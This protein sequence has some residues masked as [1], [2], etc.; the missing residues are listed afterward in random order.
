MMV[1][2]LY[3]SHC[4]ELSAEMIEAILRRSREHNPRQGITGLLRQFVLKHPGT[5]DPLNQAISQVQG[6]AII[7]GLQ[8]STNAASVWLCEL[9]GAIALQIQSLWQTPITVEMPP[10][11]QPRVIAENEAVPL[12]LVLNE[13]LVNAVKHGGQAQGHVH[14]AL[15]KSPLP[16]GVQIIIRNVGQL[17]S[18]AQPSGAPHSGLQLI[19]ALMPRTGASLVIK[20]EGE[21]VI[22]LL[23]LAPPV[24]FYAK[25]PR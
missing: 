20:Q 17:A 25:E 11:R 5:A 10:T 23:E 3:A 7:Y 1:R 14:I 19:A 16:D 6:I 9:V 21:R 2:L 13:L 4:E 18:D 12:A 24:I 15:E 8:G 22:T